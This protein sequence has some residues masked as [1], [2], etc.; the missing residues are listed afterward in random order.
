V[1]EPGAR[2]TG[3]LLC[4]AGPHRLAFLASHVAAIEASSRIS[5]PQARQA[6]DLPP[7]PGRV[8]MTEEGASL[9][10]DALEVHPEPLALMPP[11]RLVRGNAGGSLHGFVFAH[12]ELWPVMKLREFSAFL[13]HSGVSR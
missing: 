4:R 5:C 9:A 12:E 3:L 2:V 10:V 1:S 11:P 13:Q 6:F 8:L 7:A